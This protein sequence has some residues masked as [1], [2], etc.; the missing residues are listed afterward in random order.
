M[1]YMTS[2][3]KRFNDFHIEILYMTSILKWFK[4]VLYLLL[5]EGDLRQMITDLFL[6]GT[7]TTATSLQ[8]FLLY[9]ILYPDIQTKCREEILK[10][11]LTSG[12]C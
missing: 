3:L 9:M 11:R 6:A 5:P 12:G 1:V 10:V 7:E 8:W 2:I 4:S